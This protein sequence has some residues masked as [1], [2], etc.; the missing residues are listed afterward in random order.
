MCKLE[1][2]IHTLKEGKEGLNVATKVLNLNKVAKS[3]F[4]RQI[5]CYCSL[6]MHLLPVV[7]F[8]KSCSK[9]TLSA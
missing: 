5:Y 7:K 2:N 4:E 3:G 1:K 8:S 6:K 9:K